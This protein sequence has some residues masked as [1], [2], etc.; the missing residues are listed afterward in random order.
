M[1]KKKFTRDTTV[2]EILAANPA[3]IEVFD[4]WGL[5]LVPS[6]A[7][8]MNAPLFKAAA[9]HAIRDAD[10]LVEELNHRLTMNPHQT[11]LEVNG[12]NGK[13]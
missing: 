5:H 3:L 9:W 6:T 7:V 12:H 8:A 4:D 13:K 1:D 2:A 10:K 11:A